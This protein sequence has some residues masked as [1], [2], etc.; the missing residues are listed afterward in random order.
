MPHAQKS[1]GLR[2]VLSLVVLCLMIDRAQA[3][4]AFADQ[5]GLACTACHVGGFGPQLTPLGREFKLDGYTMRSGTDF[6]V[7]ISAMAVASYLRTAKDQP[8]PPAPG[9]GANNNVA[10]DQ[11]SLFL[12]GG[13]GDHVGVLS[14]FTYDGVARAVAWDN[15]D[16][17]AV[18]HI[19][20]KSQDIVAGLV[21]NNN[22]GI[23][24]AW[25]TLPGWGFAYTGSALA[26]SPGAGTVMAG[27]LAQTVLGLN[28]YAWWNS[29]IYTEAG[30]YTT[31]SRGFLRAMGVDYSSP[32]PLSTPAP[33]L[34]VAYQKSYDVQNFELGAFGFFPSL[35]PGNDTSTGRSDH[36]RDLGVD[37]S[38]QYT[39]SGANIYQVNA[40]FT[41][42]QQSLNASALLGAS[43]PHDTLDDFRIDGSYY[44]QNLIGG[45]VQAFDTWGS[46]DPILYA[47]NST[48]R[49]DSTGFVFQLDG[50]PF[51][52]KPS[53]LG[54]RFNVRAGVQYTLYTKFNGA[55][56]NYDGS[57][58]NASDNNTLRLFL[59]FA[60]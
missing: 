35:H 47:G 50:T 41:H 25:N 4:P 27:A 36:Y 58:R 46:P 21:L 39:G 10:L 60:L 55:A 37:A 18:E 6:N 40:I 22:P 54:D 31:P 2:L 45:T 19:T 7:P 20:W 32:G 8:V 57:G 44:W 9:Y 23:E 28:A 17:R 49:P 42:E 5:T 15:L 53:S 33:Y 12:A 16:L 11:A 56:S 43:Q 1:S 14:Q 24:D 59:W 30:L 48:Y 52:A 26:P 3:V 29:S 34:R 51:G 38:Y 13:F